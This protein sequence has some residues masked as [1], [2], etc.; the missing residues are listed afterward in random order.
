MPHYQ[1]SNAELI[2]DGSVIDIRIDDPRDCPNYLETCC[3]PEDVTK[4]R[5]TP[6]APL[7]PTVCGVRH[8]NGI[9]FR[10]MGN[11]NNETEYGEFPWMVDV[12]LEERG[13][14]M[15]HC[16]G[17]L[18][19]ANVVLTAAHCVDGKDL[20]TLKIRAGEWDSQTT[21][22]VYE[23]QD[24]NVAQIIV[25]P[26]FSS[27]SLVN[28]V[29]LLVVSEPVQFGPHISTVCL[30]PQDFN[31][32]RSLTCAAS[33]W[34]KNTHN[35]KNQDILKKVELPI[36]PWEQCQAALRSTRLGNRFTLSNTFVCAGG[37]T[38]EDT[39]KGDGGSPL[40]CPIDGLY[41]RY[42][43]TGIVAWGIGCGENGIPGVYVNVAK[44]KNWVDAEMR[45]LNYN[46][47]S[48]TLA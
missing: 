48:Y 13:Q 6:A 23:H 12:L 18:I 47:Q 35:S 17:S 36:V 20:N 29:A 24:R 30:P 41:N 31:F 42:Y 3:D 4:N 34:G 5:L 21:D 46:T 1:C 38:N 9:E 33:G 25:H 15:H 32:D 43:Q 19:H 2:T 39:C 14:S 22:E 45:R 28:D 10:I 44:F 26:Q 37:Q 27:S 7:A 16:G 40:V 8:T 11:T